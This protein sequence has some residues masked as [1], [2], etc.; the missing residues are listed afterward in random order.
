M[1]TNWIWMIKL[2][3]QRIFSTAS[4][5]M[6]GIRASRYIASG[7]PQQPRFNIHPSKTKKGEEEKKKYNGKWPAESFN[8]SQDGKKASFKLKSSIKI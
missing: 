8:K 7:S 2:L 1:M 4:N 6:M 5:E 3:S